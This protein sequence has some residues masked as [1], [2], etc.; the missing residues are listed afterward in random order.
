[1]GFEAA[2]SSR[3]IAAD[4]LQSPFG[5]AGA[6][7]ISVLV[8]ISALGAV[9]ALVFTG[10]RVHAGLGLDFSA[11]SVLGRWHPRFHSPVWALTCQ[12]LIAL[13]MI[14]LLGT[15]VGRGAVDRALSMVGLSPVTWSARGG[16]DTLLRCT[17]P[18]FWTFFLMTG[19]FVLVSPVRDCAISLHFT[20]S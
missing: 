4:V 18:V 8:M 7:F 14:G 1:L 17:A 3:A 13:A 16:F 19:F 20:V 2:R 6:A 5:S 10:A 11:L 15:A 12:G 9:N